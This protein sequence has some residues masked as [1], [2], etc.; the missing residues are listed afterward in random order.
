MQRSKTETYLGFCLRAGKLTLGVNAIA[1]VKKDVYLL[2][3]DP[4]ASENTK[5]EIEKLKRRFSCPL[6]A[7]ENLETLVQKP[8]CKLAAVRDKS[9]AEAILGEAG[10]GQ[11]TEL[12][13]G[14][15]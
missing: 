15:D 3:A 5:K 4:S 6:A 14:S 12:I 7:A 11:I 1:C 10:K 2:I 13:G 8:H 9:L